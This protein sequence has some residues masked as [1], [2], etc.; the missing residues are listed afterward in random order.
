MDE[1]DGLARFGLLLT[2]PAPPELSAFRR[3][4]VGELRR[5]SAGSTP[6]PCPFA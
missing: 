1:V 4:Y 6:L 2:T 5:Q 3:W